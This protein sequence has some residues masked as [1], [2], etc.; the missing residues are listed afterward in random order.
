MRVLRAALAEGH[1]DDALAGILRAVVAG[2]SPEDVLAE[3]VEVLAEAPAVEVAPVLDE[4]PV[5]EVAAEVE[6]P[7]PAAARV[8]RAPLERGED[9][10]P[11]QVA[12]VAGVEPRKAAGDG[13]VVD[14]STYAGPDRALVAGAGA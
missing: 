7:E 14:E 9:V 5:V 8:V 3:S 1:S 2:D 4:T 11:Q 13:R 6:P 10:R 12:G